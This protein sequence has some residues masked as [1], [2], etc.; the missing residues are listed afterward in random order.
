MRT[1]L[2]I[3]VAVAAASLTAPVAL[4]GQIETFAP[5][6]TFKGS[7]LI[8]TS[9]GEIGQ[10]TWRA[11]NGEIVATPRSPGGGWLLLS[12]GYQDVQVGGDF[13]CAGDCRVG[14][15]LRSE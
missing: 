14:V 10:V 13:R 3:V 11:E 8:G 7:S 1:R 9:T 12:G 2:W 4:V 6:W 5:D 15:M